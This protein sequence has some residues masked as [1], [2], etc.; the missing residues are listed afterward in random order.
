MQDGNDLDARDGMA[1]A[2][3]LAGLAFSNVGVAIV[4]ALEYP[5]GAA[6]HCSHGAGNGLLLPHAM[7]FNLPERKTEFA[8]IA[9]LLGE[10][11]SEM[12]SDDA[13]ER[14]ILAVEKLRSDVGIPRR[15]RDLGVQQ[16]Q[17]RGF[18]EKAFAIKRV[19]RVNPRHPQLEDL[20]RI[21][22][23]AY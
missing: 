23:S 14:A 21:L 4:H 1:L 7:R 13:A 15:L 2:A 6:V 5:I 22:Q 3:L 11:V 12:T 17:L 10:D 8:S 9:R 19:L 20:E 16:G 18:A